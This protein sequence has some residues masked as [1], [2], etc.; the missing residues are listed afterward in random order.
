MKVT[1]MR[2][3]YESAGFPEYADLIEA[4]AEKCLRIDTVRAK[5]DDL[6]VGCSKLGGLPDIPPDFEW[7]LWQGRPL[8][9]LL[10]ID[11]E[12]V[13]QYS[14][15]DPLP[16]SG[17]LLFFYD[18]REQ[19][20]G[21]DPESRGS[22]RVIRITEPVCN[23]VRSEP[24]WGIFRSLFFSP[25]ALSFYESLSGN[26]RTIPDR[27]M[28]LRESEAKTYRE[29]VHSLSW[30]TSHQVL[31]EPNCIRREVRDM[32]EQCQLVSHGRSV[33]SDSNATLESIF[34]EMLKNEAVSWR[35][36]LQLDSDPI[37][38]MDW[39]EG[40]YLHF[41]IRQEDLQECNFSEVWVLLECA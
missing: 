26:W 4:K 36:L 2:Q 8:D 18:M 28:N 32:Q 10:Q 12:E 7:P 9:F 35:L 17:R 29:F 39:A 25:C 31:G 14:V 20:W 1:E 33:R 27:E 3:H 5:D 16:K 24:P 15:C 21:S 30:G 40:G 23:L 19:P 6:P 11:L 22:W 34:V 37:A 13:S 38:E 41:W